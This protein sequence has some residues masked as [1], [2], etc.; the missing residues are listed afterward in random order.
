V[1]SEGKR[2]APT[3]LAPPPVTPENRGS[4]GGTGAA[5]S[6]AP[7]GGGDD[8]DG[9]GSGRTKGGRFAPGA[10]GNP[11][12]RPKGFDAFVDLARKKSPVILTKLMTIA[13]QGKGL[14]AVRA[15]EIIIDRAW[16]KAPQKLEHGG[17]DGGP[18]PIS[19]TATTEEKRTRLRELQEKARARLGPALT[20]GAPASDSA[21]DDVECAGCGRLGHDSARCP[22]G[23]ASP[24]AG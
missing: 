3:A 7:P 13:L 14:P 2:S 4:E 20:E 23:A 6:A 15:C 9:N 8:D 21:D 16:G 1:E 19:A 18:I 11:G 5:V 12:G 24:D 17:P 10:S 22:D